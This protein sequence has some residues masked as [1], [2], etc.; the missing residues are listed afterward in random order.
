MRPYSRI[1]YEIVV[2]AHT[3]EERARGWYCHLEREAV[4][5]GTRPPAGRLTAPIIGLYLYI[6][7]DYLVQDGKAV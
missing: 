6:I 4:L 5:S 1:G 2:D 3:P 7:S